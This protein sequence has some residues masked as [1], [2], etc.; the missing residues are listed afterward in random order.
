MQ[1]FD[2]HILTWSDIEFGTEIG[3]KKIKT[4]YFYFERMHFIQHI[5]I[6]TS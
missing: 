3:A 5:K 1:K 6:D 2:R 4:F